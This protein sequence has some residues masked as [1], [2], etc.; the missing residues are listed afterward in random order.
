[1]KLDVEWG[2]QL[3]RRIR[4][5]YCRFS[6]DNFKSDLYI[7]EGYDGYSVNVASRKIVQELPPLDF[8]YDDKDGWKYLF[9]SMKKQDEALETCTRVD[10]GLPYD[11]KSFSVDTAK[12]CVD[13]VKHLVEIGYRVPNGVIEALE[14]EI[15]ESE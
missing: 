15:D 10:I 8:R 3:I 7:Y 9:E 4:V 1:M 5:S 6:S 12:E 13:L 2:L 14:E 11:G